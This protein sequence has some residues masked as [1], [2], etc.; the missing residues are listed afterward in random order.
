MIDREN[1]PQLSTLFGAYFGEDYFLSG[2]TL[3]EIIAHYKSDTSG[4]EWESMLAEVEQFVATSGGNLEDNFRVIFGRD[5]NPVLWEH[6]A[7]SFFRELERLL[8]M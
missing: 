3:E 2:D 8:K 1:Y 7:A 4:G 5:F 6:T